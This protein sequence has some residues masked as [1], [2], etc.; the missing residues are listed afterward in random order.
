MSRYMDESGLSG[1]EKFNIARMRLLV[2]SPLRLFGVLFYK[3]DHKL[4]NAQGFTAGAYIGEEKPGM[5][6]AREFLAKLSTKEITFLIIHEMMHIIDGHNKRGRIKTD[7]EIFNIACDHVINDRLKKDAQSGNALGD[8]I[9]MP[10]AQV[11]EDEKTGKTKKVE[12]GVI[13]NHFKDQNVIA[14][15]VYDYLM[16][17]AKVKKQTIQLGNCGCGDPQDGDGE[18]EGDGDGEGKGEGEQEGD[19]EGG[20]SKCN[21]QGGGGS[22]EATYTEIT[23]PDGQK[24]QTTAD[25]NMS[26]VDP[27]KAEETSENLQAEIRGIINS[28]MM[29]NKGDSGSHI[30]D[31]IKELIHIEMPWDTILEN[32]I[33]STVIPSPMNR[34]WKSLNKRMRAHG[35]TLPAH[36][37]EE[38]ADDLVIGIDTSGSITL[39]DLQR[40]AGI[41]EQSTMHFNH[42]IVIKHD[43]EVT[44]YNS[45]TRD[46]FS[47]YKEEIFEMKGRGG[48]SHGPIFQKIQE[49]YEDGDNMGMAIFLTDFYSDVED[50]WGRFEWIKE[51]PVKFVVTSDGTNIPKHIDKSPI[52]IKD[53]KDKEERRSV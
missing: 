33:K 24:I 47:T 38:I 41:I 6:F 9:S 28:N 37:T 16:K 3:F 46:E 21:H 39:D 5:I 36:D 31:Y 32:T 42:I 50:N 53:Q 10:S 23:L 49:L 48:T 30:F 51:V 45:F 8:V 14:E 13:I 34:S 52:Y 15:E 2:T 7:H 26:N 29:K 44:A 43:V 4:I 40:F 19:G 12:V 22:L 20:Q 35:I 11:I 25:L 27:K 17:H 18:G 1:E